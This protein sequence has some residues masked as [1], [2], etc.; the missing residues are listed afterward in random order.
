MILGFWEL[1]FFTGSMPLLNPTHSL[2][3]C[4]SPGVIAST[5]IL[6]IMV[7]NQLVE[8][9]MPHPE[10]PIWAPLRNEKE[11]ELVEIG[12]PNLWGHFKDRVLEAC[13]KK[14]GSRS[15]R[16]IWWW[17]LLARLINRQD[18]MTTLLVN[19]WWNG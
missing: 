8:A 9:G 17:L 5:T 16:Y 13:G 4:G 14:N 3:T 2:Q 1:D 19:T 18:V 11:I 15:I 7:E 12:A 10:S 6:G